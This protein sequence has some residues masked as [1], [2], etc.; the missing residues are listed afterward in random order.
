MEVL[1]SRSVLS[2]SSSSSV[3]L[4]LRF[5]S[6]ELLPL[7]LQPQFDQAASCL[8]KNSYQKIQPVLGSRS[9]PESLSSSQRVSGAHRDRAASVC[10][11]YAERCDAANRGRVIGDSPIV[12]RCDYGRAGKEMVPVEHGER[13]NEDHHADRQHMNARRHVVVGLGPVEADIALISKFHE[14]EPPF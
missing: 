5:V 9:P 12:S 14:R 11:Y 8:R 2:R 13:H 7:R 4:L 6:T 1:A 3:H 10:F